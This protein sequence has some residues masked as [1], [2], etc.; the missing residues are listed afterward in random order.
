MGRIAPSFDHASSLGRELR[1]LNSKQ[2]RERYLRELGVGKYIERGRSPIFLTGEEIE[3]SRRL[4]L[5]AGERVDLNH[6]T[7]FQVS[8]KSMSPK[9][10][11][12]SSKTGV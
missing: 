10:F 5:A 12:H 6:Y 4:D 9:N 8:R 7:I 11:F 1:D 3:L 2:S